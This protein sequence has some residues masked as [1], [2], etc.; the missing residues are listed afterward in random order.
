MTF[1]RLSARGFVA[2]N[3]TFV[4]LLLKYERTFRRNTV[5]SPTEIVPQS[6]I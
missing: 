5:L 1:V 2:L 4:T 6:R 3:S